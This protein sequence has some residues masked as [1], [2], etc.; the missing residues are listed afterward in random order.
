MLCPNPACGKMNDEGALYCRA[1]GWQLR[2]GKSSIA[3]PSPEPPKFPTD[4]S[5]VAAVIFSVVYPGLGQFYNGDFKKGLMMVILAFAAA[6][7]APATAA[8]PLLAI[9]MWAVVNAYRVAKRR[10]PLWS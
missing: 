8:I 6:A 10:T 1:C 2:P 9:W 4:K 3:Q 7:A 5:P